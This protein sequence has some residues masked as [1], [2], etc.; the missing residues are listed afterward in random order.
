MSDQGSDGLMSDADRDA[1]VDKVIEFARHLDG[2]HPT[3]W[4][5]QLMRRVF[6]A[7]DGQIIQPTRRYR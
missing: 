6:E 5:V 1:L 2:L 4:Q 3:H 7:K